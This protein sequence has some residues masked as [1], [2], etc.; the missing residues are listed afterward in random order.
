MYYE[1]VVSD[2]GIVSNTRETDSYT[3]IN[4]STKWYDSSCCY[5]TDA[6]LIN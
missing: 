1:G 4:V 2:A 5:L 6:I 3:T